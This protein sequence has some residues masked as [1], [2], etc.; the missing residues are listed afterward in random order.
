MVRSKLVLAAAAA[1]LAVGVGC[2][3][4]ESGGSNDA[5]SGVVEEV[6]SAVETP[7]VELSATEF[8][9]A[10]DPARAVAG[11]VAVALVNDG[12]IPHTLVVEGVGGL[13]LSVTRRGDRDSGKV[14]LAPGTYTFYCDIP[15]HRAAG[16]ESTLV[17]N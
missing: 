14:Q 11:N 8:D 9:F 3:D 13:K 5:A 2:S 15:G 4:G 1:V 16:M 10:P 7:D 12:A 6:E 17:V